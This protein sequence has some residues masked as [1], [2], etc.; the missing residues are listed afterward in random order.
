M[1]DSDVKA[2]CSDAVAAI[3]ALPHAQWRE[4][5]VYVLEALHQEGR[6]REWAGRHPYGTAD[7]FLFSVRR[8]L[9]D[10]LRRSRG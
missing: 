9:D 1:P 8:D 7:D 6:R 2:R 3:E 5:A 4:W 10:W